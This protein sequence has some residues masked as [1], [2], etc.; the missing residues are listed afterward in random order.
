MLLQAA[1]GSQNYMQIALLGGLFVIMYF[2]MIRPQQKKAKDAQKFRDGIKKGDT[3][4][5]LGGMHG[6]V[7]AFEDN[8]ETVILEIAS[9]VKAKFERTAISMEATQKLHKT[10]ESTKA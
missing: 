2:F 3:V 5:T 8:D 6:K 7:I 4:V 1:G 10:S 9:T